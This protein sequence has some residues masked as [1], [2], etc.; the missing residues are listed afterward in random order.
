MLFGPCQPNWRD[1]LDDY[2]VSGM[3]PL[4][5][6]LVQI[7]ESSRQQLNDASAEAEAHMQRL[8]DV[9]DRLEVF[10]SKLLWN[11]FHSQRMTLV[12]SGLL[13]NSVDLHAR[14]VALPRTLGGIACCILNKAKGLLQF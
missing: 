7:E 3:L 14:L 13:Q 2:R 12:P 11:C 5:S 9:V 4:L 8:Q 6:C 10:L 1:A